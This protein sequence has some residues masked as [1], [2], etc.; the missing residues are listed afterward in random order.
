[1]ENGSRLCTPTVPKNLTG[2]KVRSSR[3][4]LQIR[5]WFIYELEQCSVT[6]YTKSLLECF[7]SS[8]FEAYVA[9]CLEVASPSR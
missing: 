8:D 1:M 6:F 7:R 4:F 3:D 5:I 2:V 9:I